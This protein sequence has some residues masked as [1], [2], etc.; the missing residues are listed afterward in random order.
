MAPIVVFIKPTTRNI[1]MNFS[2]PNTLTK[3]FLSLSNGINGPTSSYFG[4]YQQTL[5]GSGDVS[6]R[7]LVPALIDKLFFRQIFALTDTNFVSF[8]ALMS[9]VASYFSLN[10]VSAEKEAETAVATIRS[11]F[12]LITNLQGVGF[13][14]A[15]GKPIAIPDLD[16]RPTDLTYFN[17]RPVVPAGVVDARTPDKRLSIE[18]SLRLL[19]TLVSLSPSTRLPVAATVDTSTVTHSPSP[20]ST[21]GFQ[22]GNYTDDMLDALGV[23]DMGLLIDRDRDRYALS[24]DLPS[25]VQ[26]STLFSTPVPASNATPIASSTPKMDRVHSVAS[27]SAMTAFMGSLNFLDS[28]STF[29]L[30]FGSNPTMLRL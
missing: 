14:N 1:I 21:I 2:A 7:T 22:L 19:Q 16:K 28:Q 17:F 20:A 12:F 11:N 26:P 10:T 6:I 3:K 4:V 18:F 5:V 24:P 25:V 13:A 8:S 23:D 29:Y 15:S 27:I 9:T 30:I